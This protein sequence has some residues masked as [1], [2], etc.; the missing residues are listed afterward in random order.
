MPDARGHGTS[1]GFVSLDGPREVADVRTEFQWLA[2]QPE[3]SDTQIGVWG[4]SLGGGA[5]W[6][7]V[8]AGVPFKALETF[9]TWSDLYGALYPQ[10]LGEVRSDLPVRAERPDRARSTR[11]CAPLVPQL[12]CGENLARRAH[13]ASAR[14]RASAFMSTVT[15]PSLLFQGRRDFAFDIDQAVGR[16]PRARGTEAPLRRRLR[17]RAVDVPGPGPRARARPVDP[18]VRPVPEGDA[19]RG[20]H[21]EA[22][23]GR[24]RS[25]DGQDRR[26][27]PALPA[28]KQLTFAL[29][30][31]RG[32]R[33]DA[34]KVV[35]T[36]RLPKARARAV[37][38]AG[39]DA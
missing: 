1:G 21:G 16:V 30:G 8:V 22:R 14:A 24:A 29:H 5:A 27:T 19:E 25:V 33:H 11:R 23:R 13:A 20:R 32:H 12:I 28:V 26:A 17:P 39:R 34:G 10:D 31:R 36:S 6:N 2:A 37:R 9:E 4:I 7:S 15:T 35:R 3:V 38:R 18:L